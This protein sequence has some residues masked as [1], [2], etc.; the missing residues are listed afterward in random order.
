MNQKKT[1]KPVKKEIL[2]ILLGIFFV[3]LFLVFMNSF[4]ETVWERSGIDGAEEIQTYDYQYAMIVDGGN[5]E[6]WDA[7]YTSAREQAEKYR[8]NLELM[9]S[10]KADGYDELDYMEIS[11]AAGVDGIIL[12]YN[13]ENN[14][15]EEINKA[16]EQG[17]PVVTVMNDAQDSLRQSFVGVNDYQR[18]QAYG[19]Q[20]VSLMD[21]NTRYV[22]ILLDSEE[23][24][25]EKNQIYS[26]IS[27]AVMQV[28]PTGKACQVFARNMSTGSKFDIEE[29]IRQIFQDPMG[30]PQILVCMDETTTECAYQAMIDF[31]V[32]GD[33][34][35]IGYYESDTIMDAVRKGL[36][37]VTCTLDTEQLGR[38]TVDAL[39]E[40]GQEG[41]VNSYYNVDLKFI[42]KETA[43]EIS[44]G[45]TEMKTANRKRWVDIPL[46]RKVLIA[47]G[48]ISVLLLLIDSLLYFQV[49]RIIRRM[50]TV[51]SSNVNM[52]GLSESLDTVQDD[53]YSYLSVN[54]SDAL[55]EYYRSEQAYRNLLGSLNLEITSNPAKLLERKIRRMSNTYSPWRK[56]R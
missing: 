52:T 35:I 2:L 7:V 20:V 11:I 14:L 17:I 16:V 47:V 18:G 55:E 27:N 8:V 38:D 25:L 42:T 10:S 32:V 12:E 41:R 4:Y 39:W 54:S 3:A 44:E 34:K 51:Y 13:G 33:V 45:E 31:N 53:L 28:A 50:D 43:D 37:P 21:E 1:K 29:T 26:L 40:Y 6:L 36:I 5:E 15:K 19:E 9:V 46:A 49:N 23:G 24:D 56:T 22:L 30:P 48:S